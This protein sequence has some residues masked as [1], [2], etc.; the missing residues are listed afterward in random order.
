MRSRRV[1]V[2]FENI[3]NRD[4]LSGTFCPAGTFQPPFTGTP[5]RDTEGDIDLRLSPRMSR[6]PVKAQAGQLSRPVTEKKKDA[7]EVSSKP[8]S[9]QPALGTT[10]LDTAAKTSERSLW[11]T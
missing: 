3:N 10:E 11:L 4:I 5:Q 9:P 6:C 2:T 8:P 1:C 7:S